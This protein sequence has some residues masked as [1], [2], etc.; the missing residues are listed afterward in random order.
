MQ[1]VRA[2]APRDQLGRE[3]VL[4]RQRANRRQLAEQL[5]FVYL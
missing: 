1:R 2:L 4:D 3:R 5:I